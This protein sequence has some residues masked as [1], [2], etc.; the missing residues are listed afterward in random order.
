MATVLSRRRFLTSVGAL[1]GSALLAACGGATPAGAPSGQAGQEVAATSAPA[2]AAEKVKVLYWQYM[3]D[4]P[5]IE[6][7]ILESF[8]ASRSDIDLTWEY[9]PWDEYWTKIN[10]T[11]AA[12][13]PP[14]VWNTAPTFYFEYILRNQ[15]AD[16][17]D[18]FKQT[19]DEDDFFT[20]SLSGYDLEEKYYGMP[21][22][23]VTVVCWFNKTLFDEAGV[24]PPPLDGNWTW[25]DYLQ[26]AKAVTDFH[27][28]GSDKITTFG[29]S[30]I[31]ALGWLNP[32]IWAN[33]GDAFLGT[34]R[35]DLKDVNVD[36]TQ[37]VPSSTIGYFADL[38]NKEKVAPPAGEFE[39]QGDPMLTGRLAMSFGLNF[40]I[41]TYKDAQFEC[42]LTQIPKGSEKRVTYGGADGL[43]L[44]QAS[45]VKSQAWDLILHLIDPATGGEFLISSGAMPVL[46]NQEVIDAYL[47]RHPEKNMQAFIDA[48][49]VC[50]NAFCLGYSEFNTAVEDEL[51]NLFLGA[52]S[53]EEACSKATSAGN[54]AIAK[55]W[56]QY[57]EAIGG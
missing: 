26:K 28:K 11:L 30:T 16:L 57:Q 37:P 36:L 45:Q 23:I 17:T 8:A 25:D 52:S 32:L 19:V 47:G 31:Q 27:N 33:G 43:V 20:A 4:M 2:A 10:A 53:L 14:D 54:A 9:I 24:E 41:N 6:I 51:A 35:R 46:K 40:G 3:T 22:N 34:F 21:R 56:Q 50:D 29:A 49:E 12:G 15:L 7:P 55:I 39:G 42:N 48:A 13:N 5:D 38:I 1:G 44:S 18:L